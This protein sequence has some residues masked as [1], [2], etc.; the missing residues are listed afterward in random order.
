MINVRVMRLCWIGIRPYSKQKG[1]EIS[2][3]AFFSK[4]GQ[5]RCSAACAEK[6]VQDA[7]GVVPSASKGVAA[8][9]T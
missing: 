7:A 1:L 2:C 6:A 5:E 4:E 8:M 3:L 9:A